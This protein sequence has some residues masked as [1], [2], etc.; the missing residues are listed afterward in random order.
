MKFWR[1]KFYLGFEIG[2][3]RYKQ[4][5]MDQAGPARASAV[6]AT[7]F[8]L[9]IGRAAECSVVGVVAFL[10]LVSASGT[11]ASGRGRLTTGAHQFVSTR[12]RRVDVNQREKLESSNFSLYTFSSNALALHFSLC[13]TLFHTSS[14]SVSRFSLDKKLNGAQKMFCKSFFFFCPFIYFRLSLLQQ[15]VDKM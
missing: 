12:I 15:S 13:Y 10:V 6:Q 4:A 9:C 3:Y 5:C 14:L 2:F 7:P 11:K 1:V 8:A